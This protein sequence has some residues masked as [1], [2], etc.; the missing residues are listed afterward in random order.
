MNVS[1]APATRSNLGAG[2]SNLALGTGSEDAYRADRALIAYNHSQD[3]HD[4]T[5]SPYTGSSDTNTS[6][7]IGTYLSVNVNTESSSSTPRSASRTI[8][9]FESNKNYQTGTAGSP[10]STISGTW[11]NRGHI[12][13]SNKNGGLFQRTA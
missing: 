3:A 1:D 11:R 7:P 10:N 4:Y 6:F 9:L 12:T 13:G 5:P 8:R 2:T